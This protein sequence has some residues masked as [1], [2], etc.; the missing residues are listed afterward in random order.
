MPSPTADTIATGD[1]IATF[2]TSWRASSRENIFRSAVSSR[3]IESS[4]TTRQIE[5]SLE[6]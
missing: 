6:A 5:F 1:S 4:G 3:S 2:S